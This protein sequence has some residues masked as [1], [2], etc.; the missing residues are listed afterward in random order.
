MN[1]DSLAL[2]GELRRAGVLEV[3]GID[4]A[5][6]GPLAGPV[7]AAAV[8]FPDGVFLEGVDDSKKVPAEWRERLY[9]EILRAAS[10]GI[11]IVT[12]DE[13]DR[14]NILNAT[15]LAMDKAVGG[16]PQIPGH[17]LI[18]GHMYRPGRVTAGISWTAVVGG[19]ALCFSIAAA[20]IVAKVTRDRL[21]R[22]FDREFPG[23]GF[24]RHKGYGTAEHRAAIGRLG[25][26]PIHRR[27]FTLRFRP[28]IHP[29]GEHSGVGDAKPA[30]GGGPG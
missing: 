22:E 16:L 25:L 24:A 28:E 11:G 13:I 15:F 4:E 27:S 10:V 14:I 29:G 26:C 6:R 19:D 7:V 3:A 8:V 21:M 30:A 1:S 17:L 20:S 2:A 5:G 18:D 23:F 9:D 12:N